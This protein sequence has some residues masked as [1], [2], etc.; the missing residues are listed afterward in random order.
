ME[1]HTISHMDLSSFILSNYMTIQIL[2]TYLSASTSL[3]NYTVCINI[4][5]CQYQHLQKLQNENCAQYNKSNNTNN[6]LSVYT[7]LQL[8]RLLVPVKL[9]LSVEFGFSRLIQ[10]IV[11]CPLG[12]PFS[13]IW[14][15][16]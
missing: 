7:M 9:S 3:S 2:F 6:Q 15:W 5:S 13:R 11:Q 10:S 16:L 8:T 14:M 12:I 4:T 1:T